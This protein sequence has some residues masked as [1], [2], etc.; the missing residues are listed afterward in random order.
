MIKCDTCGKKL[1]F[2]KRYFIYPGGRKGSL[3]ITDEKMV[4][5]D[6]F[7]QY[8]SG[9]NVSESDERPAFSR[10]LVKK[11]YKEAL[12]ILDETF[13]EKNP[14]DWYIRGNL[15]KKLKKSPKESI[16]CYDEALLLD[17]HYIKAWY[18]KGHILFSMQ[19]YLEA[20]ECFENV[21]ELEGGENIN[22]ILTGWGF[23]ALFSC[24][25][26]WIYA[27]NRLANEGKVKQRVSDSRS[28]WIKKCYPLLTNVVPV[29]RDEAGDLKYVTLVPPNLGINEVVDYCHDNFH[30]ILESIEP[31]IFSEFIERGHRH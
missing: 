15:L 17:T 18:R 22:R 13:D 23:S 19:K 14:S 8:S 29:Y 2:K 16:K 30:E 5:M 25:M 4:C 21:I 11:N 26:S 28:K 31:R 10:A 6:C 27:S 1:V 20:A 3:K 9:I 24:M 12:R 7:I